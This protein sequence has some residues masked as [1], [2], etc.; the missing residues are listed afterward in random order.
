MENFLRSY[1]KTIFFARSARV[2][3]QG[4]ASHLITP[5]FTIERGCTKKCVK[6]FICA[7]DPDRLE[8]GLHAVRYHLHGK[9]FTGPRTANTQSDLR[10]RP[11]TVGEEDE[12]DDLFEYVIDPAPDFVACDYLDVNPFDVPLGTSKRPREE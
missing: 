5:S 7:C 4:H 11:P 6:G 10:H 9:R 3:F 2:A 12:W 1:P 8:R